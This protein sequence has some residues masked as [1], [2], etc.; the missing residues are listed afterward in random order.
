VILL[1]WI[2]RGFTEG[3]KWSDRTKYAN[4]Y[5]IWRFIECVAVYYISIVAYGWKL[6][7][8]FFLIGMFI[9]ERILMKIA[10]KKWFKDEG[11]IFKLIWNIPRHRWQDYLILATGIGI[12]LFV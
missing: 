8:V 10:S 2:S 12:W 9:Y 6:P 11:D 5:H 3:L 7:T 4:E 1:Y